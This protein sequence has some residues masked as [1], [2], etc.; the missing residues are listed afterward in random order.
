VVGGWRRLH[1]V[2]LHN[3]YASS[4]IVKVIKLRRI[5]RKEHVACMVERGNAYSILFINLEGR[6]ALRRSRHR[7]EV[8]IKSGSQ[9]SRVG[10]C[11]LDASG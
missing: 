4:N 3:L 2:E 10:R 7:W 11:G 1:N 6:G 8:N 5:K 9:E